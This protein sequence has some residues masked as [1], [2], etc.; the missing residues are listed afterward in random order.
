MFHSAQPKTA[1]LTS[2][3]I[4]PGSESAWFQ[5]RKDLDIRG[6]DLIEEYRACTS[7]TGDVTSTKSMGHK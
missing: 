4:P 1:G 3:M 5:M 7:L 2:Y 6:P